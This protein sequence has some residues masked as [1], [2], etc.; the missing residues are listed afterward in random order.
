MIMFTTSLESH[1]LLSELKIPLLFLPRG[2]G[3]RLGEMKK[4]SRNPSTISILIEFSLSG[5]YL[6]IG[7]NAYHLTNTVS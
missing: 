3:G 7:L 4:S 5:I 2:R 1:T 6:S